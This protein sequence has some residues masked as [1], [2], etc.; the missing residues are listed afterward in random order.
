MKKL[1]FF[2]LLATALVAGQ[3]AKL[4]DGTIIIL[5]DD[6]T[7]EKVETLPQ[8]AQVVPAPTAQTQSQ[9]AATPAPRPKADPT[10]QAYAQKLQGTWKSVDGKL[11]YIFDGDK[12]TFIDGKKKRVDTFKV[13]KVDPA[14][15]TFLLNIGEG[16][17]IGI[18]SFG[19]TYRKLA[20]GPGFKTFTDYSA[21]IPTELQ[22]VK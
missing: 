20:F 16:E 11:A 1:L 2:A 4:K 18:F 21:S 10:A 5:K 3:Y 19:G 7:W 14:K 12:V 9:T 13:E 6:G 15:R 8:G 17:K 22:K